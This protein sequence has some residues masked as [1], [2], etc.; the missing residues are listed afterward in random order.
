MIKEAVQTK[1]RTYIIKLAIALAIY[2]LF[3]FVLPAPAPMTAKGMEIV[4]IFLVACYFWI[5]IGQT[6]WT[7]VL[8]I[9]LVAVSG[10][11]KATEVIQGT[12]GDWMFSFLMGCMLVNYVLSDTGLSRRI[13]MWFITRKFVRGRPWMI[14]TMFFLAMFVLGLGM[15]SSATCVMFCAL[16]KEIL[17]STG[18]SREDRF[19]QML[20]L[21]IAGLTIAGNG[22][23]AI[24]HGNFITGIGWVAEAAGIEISV[25]QSAV[26]GISVGICWLICMVLIM[27]FAYKMD[28]SKLVSLDMDALRASVP[29]ISKREKISAILFELVIFMWVAS[30]LL[31]PFPALAPIGKF[32]KGLGSTIPILLCVCAMC[33][34]RIEGKPIMSFNDATKK[35]AWQSCMMIGT[36]RFLGT[37]FSMEDLGI[38]TWITNL[39]GPAT[40]HLPPIVFLIACIGITVFV[41]N[42][43]SNSIAMLLFK[44]AAPIA[45]L[46]P[47]VNLPALG[48]CMIMAAHYAIWTPA[49]TT[50]TSFVAGNGDV[51]GPFM[52]KYGWLPA[53]AAFLLICLVGYNIGCTVFAL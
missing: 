13:A 15:T 19:S 10:V 43:V 28:A 22:M 35:I 20:Y 4:G 45:V 14:V 34:I 47:G 21:A 2:L 27:K 53:I 38:V 50:T 26:I 18:Y 6:G 29:P 48:V 36:V 46:M 9:C 23:T 1:D 42:L 40:E 39:F 49:C 24:G 16:A 3:K 30:D 52:V 12:F 31:A 32:C 41:T 25:F 8:T 51:E 37:V 5:V 17:D 33:V 44:V 7:S 11:M